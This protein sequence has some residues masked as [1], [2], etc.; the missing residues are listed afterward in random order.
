MDGEPLSFNPP[1]PECSAIKFD[2]DDVLIINETFT[3]DEVTFKRYGANEAKV[4]S[5]S[6]DADYIVYDCKL[7]AVVK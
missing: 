6:T 3:V 4:V 5:G 2:S 7:Y 1:I